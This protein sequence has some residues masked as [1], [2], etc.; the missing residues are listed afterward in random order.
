MVVDALFKLN[1][2]EERLILAVTVASL[3]V[4]AVLKFV[5]FKRDDEVRVT[6]NESSPQSE[7][8]PAEPGIIYVYITG[9][10]IKP[11]MYTMKDGDRVGELVDIAGGFTDNADTASVNLAAKLEDEGHINIESKEA[12]SSS[13]PSRGSIYGGKININTASAEELD[14]FLPGIGK[15][16]AGNI[17][18]HR[19]KTGR[20]KSVEDIC[21]VDG[22]GNGKKYENIRDKIT[23]K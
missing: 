16:L 21:N 6:L 10:I 20:F 2:T 11:G 12:A 4:G 19:E 18:S 3:I 8:L 5:V 17:I 9:E 22:I 23:V 1:R 13:G 14:E 7:A 15:V